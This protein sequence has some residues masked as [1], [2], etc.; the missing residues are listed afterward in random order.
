MQI[1]WCTLQTPF[2]RESGVGDDDTS[3]AFDGY[4]VK[5]WH[6]QSTDYGQQWAVGDIIGT[7]IDFQTKEISFYRNEKD[8]G[9][10]FKGIKTGPNMAYFPAIF[11]SEGTEV[12]F[13]FGLK[14]FKYRGDFAVSQQAPYGY[15]SYAINETECRIKDY[16]GMTVNLMETLKRYLFDYFEFP[17]L[18]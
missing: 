9:V 18:N 11:M 13:N 2:S 1:G 6:V 8:L 17:N 3:Y 5:K 16:Y 10:A 12:V 15:Q 7:V 14:P 4:R